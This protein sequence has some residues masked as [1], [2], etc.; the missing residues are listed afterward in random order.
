MLLE[1]RTGAHPWGQGMEGD[2]HPSSASL[3]IVRPAPPTEGTLAILHSGPFW[4]QS[5]VGKFSY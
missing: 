5:S 2:M 1:Q 4:L 3:Q